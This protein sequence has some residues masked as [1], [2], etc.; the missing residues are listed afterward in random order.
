MSDTTT[1]NSSEKLNEAET[2]PDTAPLT[3]EEIRASLELQVKELND[4]I[5]SMVARRTQLNAGIKAKREELDKSERLLK[6]ATPKAKK[7]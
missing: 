2:P 3:V 1:T 6:A 7:S 4:S 5:A